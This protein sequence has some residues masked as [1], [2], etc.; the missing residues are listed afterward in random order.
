MK[1]STM[2]KLLA[3]GS[4]CVY[5]VLSAQ[6]VQAAATK[7]NAV[8]LTGVYMTTSGPGAP[9]GGVGMGAGPGAPPG[10]PAGLPAGLSAPPS[11]M[12]LLGDTPRMR[13][14]PQYQTGFAPYAGQIIQTPGRVTIVTEFNHMIRRVYLDEKFPDKIEPSYMGYSIGH[15]E[16]NTLVVETRGLKA[17]PNGM[18]SIGNNAR[19][20]ERITR[21]G[22]GTVTQV[23][24]YES[25]DADGKVKKM[26]VTAVNALRPDLHLMEFICEDGAA[27]FYS[28]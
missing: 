14:I 16:G 21:A 20:T 25:E 4:A 28:N 6:L 9:G 5:S 27:D 11:G 19:V 12:P 10:A 15:W 23:A 18:G 17:G 1:H 22:D 26:E 13:C 2:F 8:D 7:A 24:M 3:V